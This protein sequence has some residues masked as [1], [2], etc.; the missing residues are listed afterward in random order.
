MAA[1]GERCIADEIARLRRLRSEPLSAAVTE[2]ALKMLGD[3]FGRAG[4]VG[5]QM[6]V[7]TG[8]RLADPKE[9]EAS[10]VALATDVLEALG[11]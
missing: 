7:R 9:I 1:R 4:A 5:S 2:E 3:L 10:C 8:R 6:A 11:E